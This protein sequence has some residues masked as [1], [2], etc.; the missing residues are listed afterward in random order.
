MN[1]KD[2]KDL[3]EKKKAARRA[4]ARKQRKQAASPTKPAM[5]QSTKPGPAAEE[6][7]EET[8]ASEV[9]ETR[10]SEVVG[11]PVT[12]VAGTRENV[13]VNESDEGTTLV[14]EV[15][16]EEAPKKK[17]RKKK[18]TSGVEDGVAE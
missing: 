13:P 14:K 11:T 6:V 16:S 12:E 10:E 1:F 4:L 18:R 7:V 8:K 17:S 3:F 9:V 15:P 5:K 2:L